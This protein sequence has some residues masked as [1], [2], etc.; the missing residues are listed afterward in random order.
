MDSPSDSMPTSC[1]AKHS[2][3]SYTIQFYDARFIAIVDI[4]NVTVTRK[5]FYPRKE[6]K[7]I[8]IEISRNKKSNATILE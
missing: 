3:E 4:R 7:G 1:I 5:H 8:S 2:C 6:T